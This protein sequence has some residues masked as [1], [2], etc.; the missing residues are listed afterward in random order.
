MCPGKLHDVPMCT[1]T[2]HATPRRDCSEDVPTGPVTPP[3]VHDALVAEKDVAMPMQLEVCVLLDY[4][5][6]ALLL[7]RL[8]AKHHVVAGD[9]VTLRPDCSGSAALMAPLGVSVQLAVTAVATDHQCQVAMVRGL[10]RWL[11]TMMVHDAPPH[12]VLSTVPGRVYVA[13]VQ[14]GNC[15]LLIN[16]L[17]TNNHCTIGAHGT[18]C[19]QQHRATGMQPTPARQRYRRRWHQSR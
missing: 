6:Q 18:A 7:D 14:Q 8:P 17:P 12:L 5:S 4:A 3:L 11:A 15:T 16:R 9:R 10:P 1:S 19:W 13:L 2:P